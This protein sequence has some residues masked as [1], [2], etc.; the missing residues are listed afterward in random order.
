MDCC[1]KIYAGFISRDGDVHSV[2]STFGCRPVFLLARNRTCIF[3]LFTTAHRINVSSVNV[4]PEDK[5]SCEGLLERFEMVQC[6]FLITTSTATCVCVCV[7]VCICANN[8][9][10]L[11]TRSM[12]YVARTAR[13]DVKIWGWCKRWFKSWSLYTYGTVYCIVHQKYLEPDVGTFEV[14]VLF[15]NLPC[16]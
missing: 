10:G 9:W 13:R 16:V 6:T 14:F 2:F 3:L 12:I 15:H 1:V 7:C 5:N 8:I 11:L 4:F